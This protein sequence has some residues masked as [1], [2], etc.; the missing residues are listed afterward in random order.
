M[1]NPFN[2]FGGEMLP[3]ERAC[4]FTWVKA[5]KP[6]SALEVGTG[7]GGGGTYYIANAMLTGALF[8][9]DPV[10]KPSNKFLEMHHNVRFS[11]IKSC[12]LI[13]KMKNLEYL[14][15]GLGVDEH[16]DFIFFDGPEDPQVA[17]DDIQE[18]ETFIQ[19][20]TKFSMHDWCTE[21]RVYDKGISTKAKLIRPYMEQSDKWK[22]IEVLDNSA[23]SVGLCLYEFIG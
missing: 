21:E 18:L 16:I 4:L 1:I 22:L 9:C 10:R 20:G 23:A 8:T 3:F 6:R 5:C 12:E 7:T 17:L 13:Q 2:E 15:I 11:P 14:Y 19:P